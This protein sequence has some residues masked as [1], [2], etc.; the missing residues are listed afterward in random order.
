MHSTFNR[1]GTSKHKTQIKRENIFH[2]I[3]FQA[4][5]ESIFKNSLIMYSSDEE[6]KPSPEH[7]QR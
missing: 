2:R 7:G 4:D 5:I 1:R 6:T 3:A